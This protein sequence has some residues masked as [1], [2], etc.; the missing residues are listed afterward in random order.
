[1]GNISSSYQMVTVSDNGRWLVLTKAGAY[2]NVACVDFFIVH[3][4]G[5]DYYRITFKL[6]DN[7]NGGST[8]L[9]GSKP[10]DKFQSTKISREHLNYIVNALTKT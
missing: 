1:M 4:V 8:E 6:V 10:I 3:A 9:W 7:D 5:D 2:I